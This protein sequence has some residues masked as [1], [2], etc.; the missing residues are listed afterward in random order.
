MGTLTAPAGARRLADITTSIYADGADLD[1]M[2]ELARSEEIGGFTTNPT[3]MR[4][5]GMSDYRRF[6]EELLALTG[7]R[8]TSFEVVA[9]D[10]DGM[11]DEAL[12]IARWGE[13]VN[14]KIP[15]TTC[16]G[17]P[18]T[19]L[20]RELSQDH[21][22]R[23]NVTALFTLG[24]VQEV[25]AAVR[26]GAPS[27]L[28]IFAG[29]IADAGIDPTPVVAEAVDAIDDL[30]DVR[31]IWASPRETYN[32]IQADAVGCD[33]ITMTPGLI[34]KLAHLG[35]DLDQF[36]LE[37]VQEFRRDALAAGLEV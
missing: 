12:K 24:Q 5:A 2:R 4:R 17:E 15:V 3:I 29:R 28:S 34:D 25:A 18:T 37:T 21:G 11:R 20:I 26:D 6:A 13:H 10:I 16:S 9:D 7:D 27:F 33:V 31:L 8:P 14:V 19:E 36:S 1:Q 23:V 22:V 35:K 30:L 32:L